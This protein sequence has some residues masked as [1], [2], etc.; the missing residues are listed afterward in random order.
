MKAIILATVLTSF[1]LNSVAACTKWD[2]L[3]GTLPGRVNGSEASVEQMLKAQQKTKN[4]IAELENTI[5]SC[6]VSTDTHDRL[7]DW[8]HYAAKRYN[9]ELSRFNEQQA[10]NPVLVQR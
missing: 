6:R 2:L 8:M 9:R 4:Y 10:A 5:A 3:G 7:V 1:S